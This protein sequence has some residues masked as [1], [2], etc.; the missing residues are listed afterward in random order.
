MEHFAGVEGQPLSL[1]PS[2][3]VGEQGALLE[4]LLRFLENAPIAGLTVQIALIM[5]VVVISLSRGR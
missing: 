2:S 1:N 5:L 4:P 3:S